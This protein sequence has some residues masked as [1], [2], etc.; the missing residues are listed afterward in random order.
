MRVRNPRAKRPSEA[1]LLTSKTESIRLR[2]DGC[3]PQQSARAGRSRSARDDCGRRSGLICAAGG[4]SAPKTA[5]W[6]WSHSDSEVLRSDSNAAPLVYT[7][8]A[9]RQPPTSH[10]STIPSQGSATHDTRVRSLAPAAATDPSRSAPNAQQQQHPSSIGMATLC[11]RPTD[12]LA[13]RAF[14]GAHRG[15]RLALA[16]PA[17]TSRRPMQQQQKQKQKQKQ[18]GSQIP[19]TD[20]APPAVAA[21]QP[22]PARGQAANGRPRRRRSPPAAAPA[23]RPPH[24]LVMENV[25]ILKRGEPIPPAA[26]VAPPPAVPSLAQAEEAKAVVAE[27][28]KPVAV[29]DQGRAAPTESDE[30]VAAAEGQ[31]GPDTQEKKA[32]EDAEHIA[33]DEAKAAPPAVAA[34]AHQGVPQAKKETKQQAS[35]AAAKPEVYAGS[36]FATAA[37]DPSE[38]PI[39]VLLLKTRGRAPRTIRASG[40]DRAPVTV[41]AAA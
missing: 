16:P 17:P 29:A 32:E 35:M 20:S 3:P 34:P 18:Q 24:R 10:C 37:P 4:E 25:V 23:S 26:T 33:A 38:L 1:G 27:E 12:C 7:R 28:V 40:D 41:A 6:P 14:F 21:M 31:R 15:A 2:V 9:P 30:P 22:R 36:S 8:A 39:P 19:A 13:G 5:R 11:I